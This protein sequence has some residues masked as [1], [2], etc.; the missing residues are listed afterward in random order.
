MGR[1]ILITG[2]SGFIGSFIVEEALRLGFDVWAGMRAT[3]S[4]AFL[5]DERIHF[6]QLNLGNEEELRQQL[7]ALKKE[8]G[9]C[10]WDFVV[11]AAGATK[12]LHK[13]QFYRANTDG[14]RHLIESLQ[15]ED[16]VPQRFVF[17]SSLSIFGAIREESVRRPSADNPWIYAPIRLSDQPCPNTEYGK[18]KLQAE[19]FLISQCNF[20]YTI[21]R[22]TGVY[23]PRERDYFMM[24][25][26]I[27]QHTD[28][29]VGFK[30]Q[31]I[32]FVYVMDVVQAIFRCMESKA[33]ERKA[34]F[35]SD[36][37]VY[38]SRQF[39]DLLQH[40]LGTR[41]VLHLRLPLLL[42]HGICIMGSWL[43]R[44]TGKITALNVD[45]YHI[46]KQRNW[47]C[48]IEP[49]RKD[50][51][52]DPQWTLERGVEASVKWYKENGWL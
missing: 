32:T 25:K 34:Y 27:T 6:A 30:R 15:K 1:S 9:G 45:K 43:S 21:L 11:H 39:S 47:Q 26:S 22:P 49:A 40:Y 8:M 42:L 13:E 36:G 3:S 33:A 24:A 10:G 23:G 4:H 41:C 51:N 7:R 18:S 31:E 37:F 5:T 48:D 16:M 28:V 38:D 19:E 44:L 17:L 50:F 46:L 35:L 29:A 2:A 20:P 12:C 14:T 52:F